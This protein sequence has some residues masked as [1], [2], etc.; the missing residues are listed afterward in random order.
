MCFS[1]WENR[2]LGTPKF[3]RKSKQRQWLKPLA[4][5]WFS[6]HPGFNQHSAEVPSCCW[7]Q[8]VTAPSW[9]CHTLGPTPWGAHKAHR[10]FCMSRSP[11]RLWGA[12][13]ARRA[14]SPMS[15]Y[16][17]EIIEYHRMAWAGRNLKD[18]LVQIN[19]CCITIQK[20]ADLLT[21]S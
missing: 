14:A 2:P 7:N 9:W 4:K 20:C 10:D 12:R 18:H 15:P 19:K 5:P 8:Q 13:R 21:F 6:V 16:Q 1:E 11:S 17:D 3:C